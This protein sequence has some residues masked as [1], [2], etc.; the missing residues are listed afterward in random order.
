MTRRSAVPPDPSQLQL[1]VQSLTQI[2]AGDVAMQHLR[3]V[4]R[5]GRVIVVSSEPPDVE[6]HARFTR[7]AG[8]R[9]T[10]DIFTHNGRWQPTGFTGTPT[11]LLQALSDDFPWL[12]MPRD[13][14]L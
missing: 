6:T 8:D 7:I 13:N 10:L 2:A 14:P 1:I 12:V 9:W 4:T 3:F 11:D 5:G